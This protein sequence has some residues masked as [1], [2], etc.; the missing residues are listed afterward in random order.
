MVGYSLSIVS[1]I[2]PCTLTITACLESRYQG[3][4]VSEKVYFITAF[5]I[6]NLRYYGG[7]G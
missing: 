6:V 2:L 3:N 4:V 5:K 1:L 7:G